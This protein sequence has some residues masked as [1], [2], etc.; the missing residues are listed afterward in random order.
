MC[1]PDENNPASRTTRDSGMTL[2]EVAIS[3]AL[4]IAVLLVA[5]TSTQTIQGLIRTGEAASGT[6][7]RVRELLFQIKQDIAA[8]SMTPDP[9]SG[10]ARINIEAAPNGGERLRLIRVD[11]AALAGGTLSA[12]WSPW[13]TWEM[14][15]RG[16]VYR[17]IG[18]EPARLVASGIASLDFEFATGRAVRVTVRSAAVAPNG[19]SVT[20]VQ[21]DDAVQP[22]N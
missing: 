3:G 6:M 15:A 1:A 21:I 22:R 14:D 20:P 16:G 13:I 10:L 11:G 17:T 9:V 18:A 7:D 8:S 19:A 12:V 5:V 4:L 2:V